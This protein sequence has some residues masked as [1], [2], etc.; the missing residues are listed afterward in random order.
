MCTAFRTV[1]CLFFTGIERFSEV[2]LHKPQIGSLIVP[3]MVL[4]FVDF[5]PFQEYMRIPCPAPGDARNV[6][7]PQD[8]WVA[9][10]DP[11]TVG[12]RHNDPLLLDGYHRAASFWLYA[13]AD[14]KIPA[15]VPANWEK[16]I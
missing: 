8:G 15:Y 16:I 14:A 11:I 1:L 13:P 4:G 10:T 9:P 2:Q 6:P 12:R 5:V 3:P 7:R